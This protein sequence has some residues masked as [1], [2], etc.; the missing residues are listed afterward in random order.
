MPEIADRLVVFKL[1]EI[2]RAELVDFGERRRVPVG[3]KINQRSK[4]SFAEPAGLYRGVGILRIGPAVTTRSLP[5]TASFGVPT[6]TIF[7]PKAELI[8]ST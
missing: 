5:A 2:V 1:G 4:G 7:K 8:S 6:G 3:I